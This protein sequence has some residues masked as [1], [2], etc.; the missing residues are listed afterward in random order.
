MVKNPVAVEALLI[1]RS[2]ER[3]LDQEHLVWLEVAQLGELIVEWVRQL[4]V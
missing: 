2:R 3:R 1:L 4:V